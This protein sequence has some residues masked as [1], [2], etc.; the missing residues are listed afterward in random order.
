[1]FLLL[2]VAGQLDATETRGHLLL[3][4]TSFPVETTEPLDGR[5]LAKLSI[6]SMRPCL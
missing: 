5:R 1:M 6:E 3:G 2:V 4:D